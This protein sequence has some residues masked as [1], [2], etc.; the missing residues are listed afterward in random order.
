ML[1]GRIADRLGVDDNDPRVTWCYCQQCG[2]P[3]QYAARIEIRSRSYADSKKEK[4]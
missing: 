4:E 2:Q 1:I 3:K